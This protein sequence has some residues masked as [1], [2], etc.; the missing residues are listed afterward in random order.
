MSVETKCPL[1]RSSASIKRRKVEVSLL[2]EEWK[3]CFSIDAQPEF[4]GISEIQEHLCT[5]CGLIYFK[6]ESA[7]GS[8]TL[9]EALEKFDWYYLPRKWEHDM[10]IQDMA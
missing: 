9:Y 4:H 7:A 10:A 1:C 5:V 2:V 3:R 8:S 6:P